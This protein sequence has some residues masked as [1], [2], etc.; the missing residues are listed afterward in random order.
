MADR[1]PAAVLVGAVLAG[2]VVELAAVALLL[3]GWGLQQTWWFSSALLGCAAAFGVGLGVAYGATELVLRSRGVALALLVG[4]GLAPLGPICGG[5]ALHRFTATDDLRAIDALWRT[6]VDGDLWRPALVIG[7]FALACYSPLLAA[8]L[9]ER[10]APTQVAAMAIGGA[11]WLAFALVLHE[12][13]PVDMPLGAWVYALLL[14]VRVALTAPALVLADRVADVVLRRVRGADAPPPITRRG[15]VATRRRVGVAVVLG[16]LAALAIGA[17]SGDEPAALTVRRLHALRG[18]AQRQAL[19]QALAIEVTKPAS[20]APLLGVAGAVHLHAPRPRWDEE[21]RR[22]E[23]V[24]VLRELVRERHAPAIE[25][26]L[27]H[28]VSGWWA[29]AFTIAELAPAARQSLRDGDLAS[30]RA[31]G[32]VLVTHGARLRERTTYVEGLALLERAA[33]GGDAHALLSLASWQ[34]YQPTVAAELLRRALRMKLEDDQ[35]ERAAVLLELLHERSPEVR[36]SSDAVEVLHV[37]DLLDHPLDGVVELML[38][39]P[40]CD[41][42]G[43]SELARVHR[44]VRGGEVV[45]VAACNVVAAWFSFDLERSRAGIVDGRG[46]PNADGV[47]RI[48]VL[49]VCT[50]GVVRGVVNDARGRPLAARDVLLR[51]ADRPGADE[52]PGLV[53]FTDAEGQFSFDDLPPGDYTVTLVDDRGAP[54]KATVQRASLGDEVTIVAPLDLELLMNSRR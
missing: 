6:L 8:R 39:M 31:V 37:Q 43:T 47:F 13:W 36:S 51:V 53:T 15:S 27:A 25:M 18:P 33:R 2:V 7:P 48:S 21:S 32:E 23:A 40:R 29:P 54:L 49:P 9:R 34:S 20:A 26:A 5:Y 11:V 44:D 52:R 12:A 16:G 30:M 10:D 24:A 3:L 41:G 1:H 35:R 14:L 28:T 38:V 45:L 19:V 46:R 42:W 22:S 17:E 50:Y 4:L